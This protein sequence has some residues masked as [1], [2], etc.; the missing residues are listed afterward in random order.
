MKTSENTHLSAPDKV[1]SKTL[2]NDKANAQKTS[3]NRSSQQQLMSLAKSFSLD[4]ALL[5]EDKQQPIS[6]RAIR[7]ERIVLIKQQQNLEKIISKAI[8]FCDDENAVNKTDQDWFNSFIPLAENISNQ[9]MQGL[10]A[11]ILAGEISKP[12]SFSLKALN[13]FKK[14]SVFDAKLFAKACAIACHDTKKLNYRIISGC[15]QQPSIFNIFNKQRQ[16]VI[17]L[18]AFGISY[19]D[20]LSLAE[21]HLIFKQETETSMFEKNGNLTMDFNG[22]SLTLTAIKNNTLF[23]FYKFTPVGVELA[24][25][26]PN[27]PE[28]DY[29]QS[30]KTQFNHHFSIQSKD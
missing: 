30:L 26:I 20:I 10:W 13:V 4:G 25:L 28:M 3:S 9:T 12:G 15:T 7:R 8:D 27:A 14:M 16:Q 11:K 29:L 23:S 21:N 1:E 17:N 18:N 24:R 5:P 6:E 19:G 2:V 22:I